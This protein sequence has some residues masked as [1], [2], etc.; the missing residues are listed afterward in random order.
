MVDL[1]PKISVLLSPF[2]TYLKDVRCVAP[3]TVSVLA[4]LLLKVLLKSQHLVFEFDFEIN[5]LTL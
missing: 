1:S 4:I 5:A 2:D 3:W